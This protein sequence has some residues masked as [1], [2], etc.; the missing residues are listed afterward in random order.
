MTSHVS[1][2]EL[3]HTTCTSNYDIELT[4]PNAH[5]W[6][7]FPSKIQGEEKLQTLR[8]GM[9]FYLRG[10]AWRDWPELRPKEAALQP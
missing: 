2:K 9:K 8:D 1:E 5:I 4:L 10:I 3:L 6:L 7:N